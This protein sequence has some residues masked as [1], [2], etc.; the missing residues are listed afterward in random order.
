M[1][2]S[3]ITNSYNNI[4]ENYTLNKKVYST[5][6]NPN[7]SSASGELNFKGNKESKFGQMV[8]KFFGKH[9][10][11][12]MYDQNWIQTASEKMTK[13][14]GEMTEHM[15]T[16]GSVL[17]SSVYMYKTAT[18]KDLESKSRK[19]LAVNQGLC[20]VIPAIGA[21][22]VSN[23]LSKFKK[24]VEYRYRGLKEQ[25]VALDQI[26]R[27]EADA[28]KAKLGNN[29]KGLSALTGLITFTLIYR[30]ITP[31]VVT[32]VASW[33]GRKIFGED[34]KA[35]GAQKETALKADTNEASLNSSF[36]KNAKEIKLDSNKVSKKSA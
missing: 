2:I 6:E 21:Y 8:S 15:A 4:Q 19:T 9:Y 13:F 20:C 1:N 14:P 25:Q 24:N 26:S 17:T 29:L 34:D 7:L 18:N 12:P 5:T 11:K 10:G 33:I 36:N 22:T 23:K 3:G 16:L 28:L 35:K 32:P 27:Q 30:Y 31:V